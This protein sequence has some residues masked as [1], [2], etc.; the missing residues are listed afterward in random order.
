MWYSSR[1]MRPMPV[2][3]AMGNI[4]DRC[5][6]EGLCDLFRFLMN[7][8]P[9]V[10]HCVDD[11]GVAPSFGHSFAIRALIG[12]QQAS[13]VGGLTP[14]VAK[15]T[16]STGASMMVNTGT[17][18]FF[19]EAGLL[20]AVAL[21]WQGSIIY[22]LEGSIFSVGSVVQW[23]RDS[24]NLADTESVAHADGDARGGVYGLFP[25]LQAW[26]SPDA[27]S[28]LGPDKGFKQVG[29]S[30]SCLSVRLPTAARSYLEL[31]SGWHSYE[32]N[33]YRWRHGYKCMVSQHLADV[34][35]IEIRRPHT[36]ECTVEGVLQLTRLESRLTESLPSPKIKDSFPPVWSAKKSQALHSNWRQM[37]SAMPETG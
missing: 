8:L 35:Q 36:P 29:Y 26:G 2:H 1:R 19:S 23:C 4:H 34:L 16:Y 12:D 21:S 13:F 27:C 10:H 20:T 5:W 30:N 9:K 24:L 17:E 32:T 22:A 6:D 33:S 37:V 11:Y 18:V 3:P 7:I 31:R 28:H 14:R 15:T 25:P